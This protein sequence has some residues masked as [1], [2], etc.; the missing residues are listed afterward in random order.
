MFLSIGTYRFES[1]GQST[2]TFQTQ[3]TEDGLVVVDGVLFVPA[4][5]ET[6]TGIAEI[7]EKPKA[8]KP[9]KG[10][11]QTSENKP[12]IKAFSE[13]NPSADTNED[14]ILTFE[15]VIRFKE[16]RKTNP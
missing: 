13:K 2:V 5:E 7:A 12:W 8:E 14:G 3:G 9:V 4:W 10:S 15:E 6:D 1:D 11:A 16:S